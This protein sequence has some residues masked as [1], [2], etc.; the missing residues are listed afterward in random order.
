MNLHR[1]VKDYG[2]NVVEHISACLD[3]MYGIGRSGNK[4]GAFWGRINAT[5]TVDVTLM[6]LA[7]I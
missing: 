5:R 4:I 7:V 3:E 6:N 2:T 1:G